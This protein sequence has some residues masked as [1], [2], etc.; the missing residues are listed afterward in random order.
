MQITSAFDLYSIDKVRLMDFLCD[1]FDFEVNSVSDYVK[2]GNLIFKIIDSPMNYEK[3]TEFPAHH[4]LNMKMNFNLKNKEDILEIKNKF[5]FYL[6][7]RNAL[8][9]GMNAVLKEEIY[10][11]FDHETESELIIKDVD[12]RLWCFRFARDPYEITF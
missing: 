1:V 4:F 5:N 12:Q 11:S 8:E 10:S 6:Y 2:A 9:G 7:R 3:F